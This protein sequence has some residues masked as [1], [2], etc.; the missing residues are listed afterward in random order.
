MIKQ[1]HNLD[2]RW[3]WDVS[4]VP[5]PLCPWGKST[6]HSLNRRLC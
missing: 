3:R 6:Q 1:V 2:I 5:Q 4:F